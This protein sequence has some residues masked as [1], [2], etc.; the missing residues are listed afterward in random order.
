MLTSVALLVCH[1][2]VVDC[3]LCIESGLA[4]S[5]AV[6]AGGG[7]GGGGGGGAT[8]FLQAPNSIMAPRTNISVLHF[9][10]LCFTFPSL[11]NCT[12]RGALES[13]EADIAP[14]SS[15]LDQ[16]QIN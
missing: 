1:D 8:F 16:V 15:R 14:P 11:R 5:D 9:I 10:P 4:V 13:G 2:N 7:G 6:G 12:L 3:P